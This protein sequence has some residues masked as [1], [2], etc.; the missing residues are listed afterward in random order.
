MKKTLNINIAGQ[1]FRIDEEAMQILSR[2]LEHVARRFQTEPGGEETI[3]DIEARIA[4]IFGCGSEPPALVSK[5]MVD[6]MIRTMGA[7]ED[8]YDDRTLNRDEAAY[9]RKSMYEPT[10][11]TNQLSK[12]LS[13][14]YNGI[15]K[16]LSA[17]L[18]IFSITLGSL[19][20]IF[21][22][23][24]LFSFV[25]LL[26]FNDAPFVTSVM[27][28]DVLN[29]HM[30]LSLALNGYMVKAIWILAAIVLLIPLAALSYL[31]IK[32]IFKIKAGPKLFRI[33]V[34]VIWA[35]ALCA[36]AILLVLRLSIYR[37]EERVEER[38][39]LKAPPKTLWVAPLKRLS[40][41]AY[42]ETA[43]IEHFRFWRNGS[44]GQLLGTADLNMYGSEADSGWIAVEKKAFSKS[45]SAARAN[46]RN[47]TFNWKLSAD[48]LYLD[49]Y[50]SIPVN[51]HWNGSSVAICLGLPEGT[52]IRPVTGSS[53]STW[54]FRVRDPEA[55]QFR[56]K[57]GCVVEIREQEQLSTE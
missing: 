45:E 24:L 56:I 46:A 38:A 9:P 10:R 44:T 27:E 37:N 20:T 34:F 1:L 41:A 14:F 22:F 35:A 7:P 51:H 13:T 47:I 25:I 3:A 11:F 19:F 6:D 4:E 55:T 33:A 5:E 17:A 39:E 26:F 8:F 12:S 21:G 29:T 40:E 30:L 32:L 50:F 53:L 43:C 2:Y 23:F 49:E 36:L 28:P 54:R 42:D 15:G 57:E 48:T 31:G 52:T 16:L 18:R